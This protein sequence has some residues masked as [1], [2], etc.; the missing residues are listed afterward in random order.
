M[1]VML[2]DIHYENKL[3]AAGVRLEH[4]LPLPQSRETYELALAELE[5]NGITLIGGGAA[6]HFVL[7]AHNPA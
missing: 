5:A 4:A 3:Q 7:K 1:P 2:V 6:P